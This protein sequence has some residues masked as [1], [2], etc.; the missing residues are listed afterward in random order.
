LKL[1]KKPDD[2]GAQAKTRN[3]FSGLKDGKTQGAP[4]D[5]EVYEFFNTFITGKSAKKILHKRVREL[6][7][8]ATRIPVEREAREYLTTF[9]QDQ[10]TV[11]SF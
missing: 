10:S 4:E 1:K 7:D 11:R 6:V 2:L 5:H 9:K 3:V 8:L